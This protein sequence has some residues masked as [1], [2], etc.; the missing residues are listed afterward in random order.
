MITVVIIHF[1]LFERTEAQKYNYESKYPTLADVTAHLHASPPACQSSSFTSCHLFPGFIPVT[2][3]KL[4]LT[5]TD[6]GNKT[7]NQFPPAA[8]AIKQPGSSK[9]GTKSGFWLCHKFNLFKLF[10]SFYN[11]Q[12]FEAHFLGASETF[13]SLETSELFSDGKKQWTGGGGI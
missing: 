6:M 13:N 3:L 4:S 8:P 11:Q 12:R 1:I 9:C 2:A 10:L 5:R 7:Q